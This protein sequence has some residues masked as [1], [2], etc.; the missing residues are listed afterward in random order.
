FLDDGDG[1][2]G[3]LGVAGKGEEEFFELVEVGLLLLEQVGAAEE[4][5][6][7][8]DFLVPGQAALSDGVGPAG[9]VD[10]GGALDELEGAAGL[11]QVSAGE[12]V[13]LVGG[14][15]EG[16]ALVLGELEEAEVDVLGGVVGQH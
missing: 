5:E 10:A 7:G 2:G 16:E 6:S 15:G 8:V 3:G 14:R 13:L 11:E 4:L 1:N 12:V 9:E